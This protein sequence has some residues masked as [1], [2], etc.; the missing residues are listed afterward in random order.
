MTL[1]K[2]LNIYSL[3]IKVYKMAETKIPEDTLSEDHETLEELLDDNTK[4]IPPKGIKNVAWRCL[5]DELIAHERFKFFL[6]GY[7]TGIFTI[8]I[9]QL[10]FS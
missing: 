6:I 5:L 8:L 3:I 2:K 10:I 9:T 1:N 4:D 7:C